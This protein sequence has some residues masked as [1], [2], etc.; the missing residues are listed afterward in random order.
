MPDE[1]LS[2]D[3]ARKALGGLGVTKFYQLLNEKKLEAVKI[4]KSLRVKRSEIE[5]FISALPSYEESKG[6]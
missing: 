6:V 5:R 4:G 3:E 1:L 2:K